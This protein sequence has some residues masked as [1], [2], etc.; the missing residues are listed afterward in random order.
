MKRRTEE[1]E[2]YWQQMLEEMGSDD[3][4]MYDEERVKKVHKYR[5]LAGANKTTRTKRNKGGYSP[6]TTPEEEEEIVY[7]RTVLKRGKY[8]ISDFLGITERT[9][10]K[11]LRKYGVLDEEERIRKKQKEKDRADVIKM[12]KDGMMRTTISKILGIHLYVIK[13]Y[14]K[15]E[16]LL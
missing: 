5:D 4:W 6:R 11:V 2:E 1:Q 15:D 12:Y 8:D 7:Q 13:G 16:G 9:V 3:S 14:L 10:V